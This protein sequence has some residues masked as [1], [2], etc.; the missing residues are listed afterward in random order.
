MQNPVCSVSAGSCILQ[1]MN[2][3]LVRWNT[4][5][6]GGGAGGRGG[7]GLRNWDWNCN[8]FIHSRHRHQWMWEDPPNTP[9]SRRNTKLFDM[10]L[11][12]QCKFCNPTE[13]ETGDSNNNSKND[14]VMMMMMV[15]MIATV[16]AAAISISIFISVLAYRLSTWNICVKQRSQQGRSTFLCEITNWTHLAQLPQSGEN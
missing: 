13:E 10:F 2:R 11:F 5:H 12:P 15:L 4:V 8:P 6:V 3:T 9:F 1:V 14:K 7:M 16:A